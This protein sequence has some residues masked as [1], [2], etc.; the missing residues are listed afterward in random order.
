M[1]FS[2]TIVF[3]MAAVLNTKSIYSIYLNSH[4]EVITDLYKTTKG[5]ID[6]HLATHL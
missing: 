1:F 5:H 4:H 2:K 6:L 3:L